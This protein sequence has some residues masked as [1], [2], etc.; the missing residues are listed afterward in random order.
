MVR[1]RT[2]RRACMLLAA[3]IHPRFEKQFTTVK[4]MLPIEEHMLG[5]SPLERAVEWEDRHEFL[6][7][8]DAAHP[9]PADLRPPSALAQS[10]PPSEVAA[11]PDLRPQSALAQ[12]R[13]PSEVAEHCDATRKRARATSPEDV[14]RRAPDK[15]CNGGQIRRRGARGTR[16]L[17]RGPPKLP[18]I[19]D[20]ERRY[21]YSKM[22]HVRLEAVIPQHAAEIQQQFEDRPA[23][24][25]P[26]NIRRVKNMCKP[27][28]AP[29]DPADF[30]NIIV[31]AQV[32]ASRHG[33]QPLSVTVLEK[34]YSHFRPSHGGFSQW[35]HPKKSCP[36]A[37]ALMD[38]WH[39][40][41]VSL[42]GHHFHEELVFMQLLPWW[43]RKADAVHRVLTEWIPTAPSELSG[44][45]V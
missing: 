25:P 15:E 39:A 20:G 31:S 7:D 17:P 44:D 32:V 18:Q 4:D 12:S 27:G 6:K 38:V 16:T 37:W 9:S 21:H 1:M 28:T 2:A 14:H 41:G 35:L 5:W 33:M 45:A 30:W 40:A 11:Q 34:I 23:A 24:A 42:T 8:L 19:T 22:E 36:H 29:A 26:R 3:K 10:C 43:M 13:S